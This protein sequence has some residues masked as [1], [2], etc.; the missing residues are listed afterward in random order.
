MKKIFTLSILVLALVFSA[1]A[2]KFDGSIKGKLVDTAAKAPIPD[3]TVSVLNAKDSS[4]ATFT[5]STKTGAFEVKGLGEGDYRL[6]VSSK[7]FVELKKTFT[8]TATEKTIDFGNVAVLKDYKTLEGVTIT[9]EAP[10][11]VKNDTVQ[12]NASGF[13]TIPNA[14]AEDLLKKLPGVDVDKDG[15]IKSQGETVPKVLV[16]GKE[17]FGNDP[18]LATKNLTADMI[19]SVQVFDDMSDQ[20]KFTKIDD[21]SRSKTINIKLKKDRNKGYFGRALVG[22]GD[23][24]K[25]EGNL[26]VNKFN[27]NKRISLLFNGNNIN[28]QGFSFSDIISSMGGF[29]GFGGGGGGGGNFGGGGM[30]MSGGR[31]GGGNFGGGGNTTGL[32]KSLSL[33]VNYSDQWGSKIKIT[34]SYFISNSNTR[35]EQTSL[36]QTT[37]TRRT[38]QE[39]SIVTMNKQSFSNNEN[40]NHRFNLRFE[41]QID[42][43][44]SLLYTPSLTL[45]HSE[46]FSDDT[47]SYMVRYP[48]QP[49]YL[50]V[51]R[52]NNNTNKRDGYNLGNNFLFRHKFGKIGR[53]V[54]VGWNNTMGESKS[55]GLTFSD[56]E[57]FLPNGGNLT[58]L[59]QDQSNHQKT[60]TRSN[61]ISTSYTE[62]F[63][64]NKLLE[65]NYAYTNT[66]NTSNKQ[67]DNYNPGSGKYDAPNLILTNNFRNTF[68]AHRFGA[69]FRVQEKKYNFQFGGGIQTSTLESESYQA[70]TN[71]DSV[72]KHSYTNFF[73][74]ASFNFTP[75]RS[76]NLRFNYNGRTNQPSIY[77]LQNV[78]DLTDTL[79]QVI[80]NPNLNQ[81]FNHNFNIGFNTFN[82]LTFR[83]IAGNIS[84]TTTQNKIVNDI[85]VS[86]PV[87]ITRYANVDG[88]Y[89]ARSFFTLGLPFKNPKMKGSS[90][91]LTNNIGLSRDVSLLEHQKFTSKTF[92]ITQGAG[93][94]IN[95]E[96]IDFG[97]K[98]NVSYSQTSYSNPRQEDIDYF[99]QTYSGDVT[100]TFPKNYILATN[101]NYLINT[102]LGE[103][104][105]QSIPM[106]NASFSKLMFKKKNGELKFSVNDILNQN[107]SIVRTTSDNYFQDTRSI[108]LKRYFMV[109]FMFNLQKMGGNSNNGGGMPGM[110][111]QM[112]REMRDIRMY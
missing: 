49:D 47:A 60:T 1:A 92:S 109:S 74:T 88:Y 39:D 67:V 99:T 11:Q 105:N 112:Q 107:Q 108:V 84:F 20:A 75:S 44:N 69:N 56:N 3:A 14:T 50:A 111:R 48:G 71:K 89:N 66:L 36:R 63:G 77:Q 100:Y 17:F 34:G 90:V 43:M 30:Q 40:Q 9:S 12:F 93:V 83:L 110:P 58:P 80:G 52:K 8:I 7:G 96:K 106:W 62:P 42:S 68:I 57:F 37:Y 41:Y 98:A 15:N 102:G 61:V 51:T 10:I 54:T 16:D 13:K 28:K 26:S 2:Q 29:S 82:I 78:P 53:T 91:N 103:G 95:K 104:Y 21:G 59:V 24:G 70:S 101:F 38:T 73:P 64:L 72:N 19:E 86:G 4:L 23:G 6:I 5:L 79:N 22:V 33:G 55:N 32:I 94:N 76:K 31:G 46:N 45:Q 25:Y 81:E 35:Q 27:G 18:K 65:L 87:Q 97:V 85:S